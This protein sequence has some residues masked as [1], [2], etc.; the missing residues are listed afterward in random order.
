MNKTQ[1][2]DTIPVHR[3]NALVAL[4]SELKEKEC[5]AELKNLHRE[6]FDASELL[7]C[8]VEG[9]R[10]VGLRF[11]QGEYYISALIMAG[12]IMRQS[13]EYLKSFLLD[14]STE[15]LIGHVL[16]GTIEGD[17]HDL[18][19]NI[20]KD[21]LQCNGFEVTD[22]GVNVPARSIADKA[23]ELDP[24]FVAMSCLLTTSLSSLKNAVDLLKKNRSSKKYIIIIG[25][26]AVDQVI[27]DHIKADR[28]FPDAIQGAAFCRR[29]IESERE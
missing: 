27:N 9:V 28:W 3:W 13:A 18:G 23:L 10:K 1:S 7:A 21:L 26:T 19:K 20:F 16:L 8:C 4:I 2:A 17:I 6:G 11:E 24:D 15:N 5:L 29:Q 12:E 14:H 22:L 25:G